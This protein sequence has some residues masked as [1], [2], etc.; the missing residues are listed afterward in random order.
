MAACSSGSVIG[1]R[2]NRLSIGRPSSVFHTVSY[3]AWTCASIGCAGMS[4]PNRPRAA[5]PVFGRRPWSNDEI[6]DI[7]QAG[8]LFQG[9]LGRGGKALQLP[10]H[11]IHDVI[12]V[13]L[14]ADAIHIPL[15]SPLYR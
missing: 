10:H 4:M 14:G 11:Q 1:G 3:S 2:S 9:I 12:C 15:H 5:P 8:E 7:A 13:V 6:G